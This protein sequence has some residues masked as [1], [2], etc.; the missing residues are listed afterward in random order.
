MTYPVRAVGTMSGTV[1]TLPDRDTS[2]TKVRIF[3]TSATIVHRTHHAEHGRR[4]GEGLGHLDSMELLDVLMGLPS[5][6][7]V[8]LSAVGPSSLRV[9]RRAPSGVVNF[10]PRSVTR[11]VVPVVTPLLAVVY[12]SHWRDGLVRASE[13]AAYCPRMFVA[14]EL[15]ENAD[16]V[17]VEASWYGVGVAVGPRSAPTVVLDPEPLSEWRPSVAWWRFCERVYRH[18]LDR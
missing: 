8:P 11:L 1:F 3:G 7:A 10:T 13:F 12:S 2:S 16:E 15:P 18:T 6:E 5:G 4:C 17:L 9:L 14:R